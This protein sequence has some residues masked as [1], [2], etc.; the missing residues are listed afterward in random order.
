M[1]SLSIFFRDYP[2]DYGIIKLLMYIKY[3]SLNIEE[4]ATIYQ[5]YWLSLTFFFII[6]RINNL[7]FYAIVFKTKE[8][9]PQI[10]ITFVFIARKVL[11][12]LVNYFFVNL[13]FCKNLPSKNFYA[14]LMYIFIYMKILFLQFLIN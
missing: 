10:T 5:R 4:I 1:V 11:I 14:N 13:L 3:Q 12:S 8:I 6:L 9:W 2:G 7:Q